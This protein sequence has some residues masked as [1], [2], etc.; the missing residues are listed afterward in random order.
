MPDRTD[1][2]ASYLDSQTISPGATFTYDIEFG[3][4]GN[5]NYT[6]GDSIFHCH[7]YPHFAQG[8]WELWRSHD[9]FADGKIGYFDPHKP[10][11]VDNDP[12]AMNLPDKEIATG[13]ETPALVPIPGTS[14]APMPTSAFRG[15]PFYIPGEAGHRPPQ[16]VLDFDTDVPWT[17]LSVAP[18][19]DRVVDGGLPRHVVVEGEVVKNPAVLENA[20]KTGGEATQVIAARVATQNPAALSALAGEWETVSLKTLKLEGEP[21]EQ[22]AM[23]FHEGNLIGPGLVPIPNAALPKADWW[24][25]KA[26]MSDRS[27]AVVGQQV[28][29]GPALF[30]VNGRNRAQGAPYAE[31]CPQDAP[32]RD[33]R[34]AFIQTELTY[35]KHGWFDPQGRIVIL[36]NDIKDI[37]DPDNRTSLPAPF[38]F[39]AN[40]GECINFKSSNFVTAALN[41]DDFQIYM[42]TDTIGQH[43]HLV[44]FDVTSSDGSGN[45]FNYEDATF[46]PQEV[47]DRIFAYNRHLDAIASPEKRLVPKA[48]P[49]FLPGGDIFE[50]AQRDA[51]YLPLLKRG[52]CPPQGGALPTWWNG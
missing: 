51:R 29:P 17:D 36:E 47:R 6:P 18:P 38:F 21:D 15:Y 9:A 5:R 13:T 37:I 39:R 33:Y 31:P 25:P 2:N 52:S 40:S 8:M 23:Q 48:H 28:N 4:S 16:P 10:V 41:V 19:E 7:L 45:G 49:L 43:I 44:K 32:Q 24:R 46:S 26:Y 3:G 42:P 20:L 22:R 27:A 1:P 35:N 11:A 34:A 50:A 12:T 30:Y 14:L